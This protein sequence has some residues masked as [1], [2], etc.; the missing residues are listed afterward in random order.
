M[1]ITLTWRRVTL[2]A[3]VVAA[4]VAAPLAYATVAGKGS[5][6]LPLR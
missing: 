4:G 3:A 1:Q 2:A 5:R 6:V